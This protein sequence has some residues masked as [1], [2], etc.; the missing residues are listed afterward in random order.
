MAIRQL[1]T[2]GNRKKIIYL[3]IILVCLVVL[4]GVITEYLI[5]G[6]NASEANPFLESLVGEPGFMILKSAGALFCAFVLFDVHRRFP[7]TAMVVT[8]IAVAGYFAIVVWN[9]SLIF[10]T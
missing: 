10:L 5:N 3:L 8:W 2:Q 1:L 6:G 7:G 9:T 4:D